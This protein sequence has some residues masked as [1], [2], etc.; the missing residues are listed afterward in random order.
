MDVS[1]FGLLF[2]GVG[3]GGLFLSGCVLVVFVVLVLLVGCVGFGNSR[4]VWRCCVAVGFGLTR[5]VGLC[6]I[7]CLDPILLWFGLY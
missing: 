1:A 7:C 4:V 6:L 5:F 2:G 3:C